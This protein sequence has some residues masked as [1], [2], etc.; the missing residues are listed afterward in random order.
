MGEISDYIAGYYDRQPEYEW[1]RLERH[2]ME[3]ALT[4]RAM[5]NYLPAPPARILDCG[6]G[7]GRYSLELA[8][9]GYRVTLFDLSSGNLRLAQGKVAGAG[10]QL[11]AY[12][13]GTATDLSRFAGE[14]FDA[15][16]LMGPLYH[17]LEI[18]ERQQ[19]LQEARRVLK[20][21]GA[22]LAAFI[23]RYAAH[24]WAALNRPEMIANGES[25]ELLRT[26]RIPL[27]VQ[28][29]PASFVAYMAH[30]SEVAPLCWQAGFQVQVVLGLEGLISQIEAPVNAL[31]EAAAPGSERL[32]LWEAW[33]ALN[34]QVAAD[35]SLHGCV[36][37][38][39]VVAHKPRWRAVLRAIAQRLNQAGIPY[40]VAGG[41][42]LAL[43]GLPLAVRDIDIEVSAED[44]YHVQELFSVQVVEPVAL[45]ST[46]LYRSHFGVFDFDGV[47]V[48]VMGDNQR[49]EG[50]AWLPTRTQT[51]DILDLDGV[52]VNASWLEEEL[53]AYI[54]RG[55]LERAAL[56]LP[57]CDRDRLLALLRGQVKTQVI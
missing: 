44:A 25:D 31:G 12:E 4:M 29:E 49:R 5:A 40:N 28:D 23:S 22:L 19:A 33:V 1:E 47:R 7:P 38:L 53:L 41:A 54:R 30:P 32:A 45:G 34:E 11:E 20:P 10:L 2:R 15:V 55:R 9:Q 18:E 50:N 21:G 8:R 13:L 16:L 43:H 26:G 42:S 48:E 17:L 37:H 36:E 46:D 39:L 27:P 3:Y 51:R 6:G 57:H 52:P 14:T 56:C 35:S 24:R